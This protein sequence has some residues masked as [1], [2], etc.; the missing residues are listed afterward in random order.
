MARHFWQAVTCSSCSSPLRRACAIRRQH[1][2]PRTALPLCSVYSVLHL[3]LSH[4]AGARECAKLRESYVT[5]RHSV[6][7]LVTAPPPAAT[8]PPLYIATLNGLVRP[9][10]PLWFPT[11]SG[12]QLFAA[13]DY[14]LQNR[15]ARRCR[16]NFS[17]RH[18][19]ELYCYFYPT[20]SPQRNFAA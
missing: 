20:S 8:P 11:E 14:L 18:C 3:S 7:R 1:A 16:R 10:S 2:T 13:T 5:A 15:A 6:G 12:A 4:V 9:P 19:T 17:R